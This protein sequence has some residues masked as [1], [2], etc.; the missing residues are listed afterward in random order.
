MKSGFLYV[1]ITAVLFATFEPIAALIK[2]DISPLAITSI[3]F[4][5][6]GLMLLP[7]S[8]IEIRKQ[9]IKFTLTDHLKMVGLGILFICT[10]M[11][12]LQYAVKMSNNAALIAII[13]SANSVS[14]IFLS[15]LLLKERITVKKLVALLLCIAGL[16]VCSWKHFGNAEELKAI[17]LAVLAALTFSIYTILNKKMMKKASGNILISFSFLYGSILLFPA[18]F[19]VDGG[20]LTAPTLTLS[21]ALIMVYIAVAV[22][23]IGYWAYFKAL[24]KGSATLASLSFFVK[25]ALSPIAAGIVSMTMPGIDIF[26]GLILVLIGSYMVS[27]AG[28]KEIKKQ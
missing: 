10:S 7:F 27:Y 24:E 5:V 14:T 17:L 21:T 8:I 19:I 20:I 16:L 6:A 2:A 28:K 12:L 26:A 25:P 22:T 9:K 4:L 13:F 15:S 11:V 18:I 3:R 1:I 23:G